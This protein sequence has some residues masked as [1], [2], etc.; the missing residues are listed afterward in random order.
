VSQ[1]QPYVYD[2]QLKDKIVLGDEER[3]MVE[4][5]LKNK[6]PF[7]DLVGGKSG[8][9]IVLC[10]GA[11]GM[12]KT[13]TAEVFAESEKRPL[14]SVQASQLGVSPIDLEHALTKVFSRAQRWNA[15][16]LLDEC[17]VF[18]AERGTS[19]EQNAIVGVFLRVME[20]FPGT[21]FMT[22]NRADLVDDAIL[23]RCIAKLEY[24]APGG[25]KQAKIWRNLATSS[26]IKVSDETI[27]R[28]TV[29]NPHLSGR[30]VKNLLKLARLFAGDGE[31]TA[32]MIERAKKFKPTARPRERKV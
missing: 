13:L 22:T 17:D 9:T 21:M 2:E 10:A 32:E 29:A 28:V 15:L 4:M 26:G 7:C 31:V 11:P 14:Y 1:I 30:D 19:L 6:Q 25:V 18:V 3:D 16:L 23:S 20:Y 12:G 24:V 27:A 5:L 8:G